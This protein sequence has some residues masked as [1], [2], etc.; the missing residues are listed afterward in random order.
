MVPTC[1]APIFFSG[2]DLITAWVKRVMT[3]LDLVSALSL[4]EQGKADTHPTALSAK[5]RMYFFDSTLA[6]TISA[7]C[8]MLPTKSTT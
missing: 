8:L 1:S 6:L 7:I 2:R 3:S 4:R 5:F